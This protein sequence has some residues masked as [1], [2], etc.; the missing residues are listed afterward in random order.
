MK[1][2][3]IA[4]LLVSTVIGMTMPAMAT[5]PSI[6]KV[7]TN[8]VDGSNWATSTIAQSQDNSGNLANDNTQI[9]LGGNAKAK[10]NAKGDATATDQS[11]HTATAK[12]ED[13]SAGGDTSGA[14]NVLSGNAGSYA[15]ANGGDGSNGDNYQSNAV[16][17]I[18]SAEIKTTQNL[19]QSIVNEGDTSTINFDDS[20]TSYDDHSSV[21]HANN[22]HLDDSAIEVTPS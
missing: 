20:T 16:V 10:S 21:V 2:A 9:A 14:A 4:L 12:E 8:N 15:S 19:D 11:G 6:T 17:Q 22:N 1:K 18:A 5:A 7:V 13:S 3:W